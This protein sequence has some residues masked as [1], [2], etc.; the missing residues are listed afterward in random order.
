MFF[1]HII[2]LNGF[3]HVCYQIVKD[4]HYELY[5]S[6]IDNLLN[7]GDCEQCNSGKLH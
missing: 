6:K 2:C 1:M 5:F 7:I 4:Y 3:L